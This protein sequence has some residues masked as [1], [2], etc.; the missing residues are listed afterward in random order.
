M[1]RK[2]TLQHFL[3]NNA[4]LKEVYGENSIMV[5]QFALEVGIAAHTLRNW[6]K[7]PKKLITIKLLALGLATLKKEKI[8]ADIFKKK[9]EEILR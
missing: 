4:H 7:D 6:H 3:K 2:K 5:K 9:F 1:E 8:T